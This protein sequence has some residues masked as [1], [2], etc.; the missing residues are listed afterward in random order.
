MSPDLQKNG[1]TRQ[2]RYLQ[3]LALLAFHTFIKEGIDATIVEVHH[4]GEFDVTNVISKSVVTGI[5]SLGMDHVAELGPTIE[6]I[7]WHKAG[8]MK[9]G[10][11]AFSAPQESGPAGVISKLAAE[12]ET[13]V[14]FV[15]TDTTLP[16]NSRVLGAPV[17][18]L[19]CSIAL[20]M[21]R[22]FLRLK[23]PDHTLDSNDIANGIENFSWNGRF[24]II[25]DG[26]SQWFIDGAHNSLS[27]Q[28]A[29]KWFATNASVSTAQG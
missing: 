7:A 18:R 25:E 5:T 16:V 11:P 13:T 6:N 12:K 29:G 21:T 15:S 20:E 17:Q 3:L 28:Q 9:T 19:N 23:A 14:K 4:G 1:E 24:E 27:L 10:A 2:P 8:I 22:A 26:Q